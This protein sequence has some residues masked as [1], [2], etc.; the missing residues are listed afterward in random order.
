MPDE[1]PQTNIETA[2]IRK[3]G[4]RT[5]PADHAA[6]QVQSHNNSL[7]AVIERVAMDPNSDIDKLERMLIL[8]EKFDQQV[9]RKAFDAAIALAKAEI[10][11]I[12]KTGVVDFEN[13]SGDRTYFKHET[14]AGIAKI[15]DPILSK[16]GLSYRYRSKQEGGSLHVTCVVAHKDGWF[17]ET[18]LS[19]APDGSGSKN[20]YQAVGSSVTYLQRYTLKL[21]LG[22]SAAN[23]DDAAASTNPH[24]SS[25]TISGD[26]FIELECLLKQADMSENDLIT[27]YGGKVGVTILNEFKLSDFDAAK[28]RLVKR[29]AVIKDRAEAN[30]KLD[31]VDEGGDQ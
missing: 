26:Q 30:K 4:V 21:A 11:P 3:P 24:M 20:T 7:V 8:K 19:G 23:D 5:L 18:T 14:L 22:L 10:P 17:E 1:I 15:V 16:F 6:M 9:S 12:L 13:K 2:T 28:A 25:E 31:N 27:A 29:A